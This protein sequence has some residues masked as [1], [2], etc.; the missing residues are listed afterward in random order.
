MIEDPYR[1]AHLDAMDVAKNNGSIL[2]YEPN[3]RLPLWPSAEAARDGIMSIWNESDIT[4]VYILIFR[5]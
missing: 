1:S 5:L 3:L 2:F 4:K